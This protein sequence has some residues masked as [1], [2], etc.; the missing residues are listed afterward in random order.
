MEEIT[1]KQLREM[2]EA[3]TKRWKES[4]FL[5]GLNGNIKENI[6]LMFDCC[7]SYIINEDDEIN[8]TNNEEGKL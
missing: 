7:P 1:L 6:A 2:R 8:N 3:T 4:G 5:D